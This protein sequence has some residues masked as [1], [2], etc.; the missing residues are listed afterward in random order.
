MWHSTALLHNLPVFVHVCL[1]CQCDGAT[2]LLSSPSHWTL[3]VNH[4]PTYMN[5]DALSRVPMALSIVARRGVVVRVAM[6]PP[7]ETTTDASSQSEP[8]RR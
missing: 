7:G 5:S 6:A 2:L 8:N 3:L 4:A 1:P